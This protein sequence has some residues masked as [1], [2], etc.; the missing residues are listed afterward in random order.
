MKIKTKML[1]KLHGGIHWLNRNDQ[2]NYFYIPK[3]KALYKWATDE[4]DAERLFKRTILLA[5]RKRLPRRCCPPRFSDIL[6]YDA[7][8]EKMEEAGKKKV[9]AQKQLRL[10]KEPR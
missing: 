7:W 8:I 3:E 9:P 6:F 2:R 4:A 10:F 5:L 1:F